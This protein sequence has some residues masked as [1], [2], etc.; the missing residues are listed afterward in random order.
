MAT[1]NYENGIISVGDSGDLVISQDIMMTGVVFYVDSVNGNDANAGTNR[2]EPK[3]TLASA[4]SAATTTQADIIIIEAGHTETSATE[5]TI[6]KGNLRIYGLGT[7]SSKPSFTVSGNV[8]LF[9]FTASTIELNNLRFPKGTAAHTARVNI[10]GGVHAVKNCDFICGANDLHSIT[11]ESP[12]GTTIAPLIEG[13]TFTIE[14][15]GPSTGIFIQASIATDVRVV[16]CTFDGGDYNFDNGGLYTATSTKMFL[17][18]N[19][20]LNEASIVTTG[21]TTTVC[22]GTVMGDGCRVVI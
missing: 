2:L 20:L 1:K 22:T 15:D 13:C 3:A 7:G 17:K 4:V 18:D 12:S 5:I 19:V 6:D 11:I 21:S 14:E 8:D 10:N 9:N 16:G